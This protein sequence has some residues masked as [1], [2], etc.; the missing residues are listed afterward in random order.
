VKTELLGMLLSSVNPQLIVGEHMTSPAKTVSDTDSI[1][2]VEEVM[3]RYGLKAV[4]VVAEGT[5][6]CVGYLEQQTAAR[7]MSHKLGDIPVSEYMHRNVLTVEPEATLF[8]AMEIILNQRQRLVPVVKGGVVVGVLTRTDIMRLFVGDKSLRIPE[9][10]PLDSPARERNIRPLLSERLPGDHVE[11]LASAGKLGDALGYS[12]YAVGG[13]VRD[14]LLHRPNLDID[15]SVEGDGIAFAKA[16]AAKFSGRMHA[17]PKFKTAVVVFRNKAGEEQRIDVA[18]ARLEYYDHPGALPH[19]E[20]SSIKMDLFRRDFTINALAVQLNEARFGILVDPFGAQR[21]IKE[22]A[23]NVLHSLSF[24]EDPTRI[25]RGIRFEKRF[26]FH[27]GQQTERL[28]KNA[29]QLNMLERLSGSRLFHEMRHVL[30]EGVA[31]ACLQ[32]LESFNI[33]AAIH[34]QLKLHPNKLA[35]LKEAAPVLAWYTRLYTA[36]EPKPWQVYLQILC[37]GNKYPVVNEIL[38]A[39]GFSERAGS[40]FMRQ[41]ENLRQTNAKLPAWKEKDGSMSGLFQLLSRLSVESILVLMC[42]N[43]DR[44]DITRDLSHFLT[45]LHFEKPDITGEDIASFGARPSPVYGKVLQMVLAAKLDGQ[46]KSREEQLALAQRLV[47]QE[48][49]ESDPSFNSRETLRGRT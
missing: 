7:A 25:L 13:F 44:E 34:P 8:P 40:D 10:N 24:I 31:V 17:H 12:V 49:L 14:L 18:T 6:R 4:P 29:M 3:N 1:R 16:L 43:A 19:V 26:D 33:L 39:F 27:L 37:Q 30:D 36:R 38:A 48:G 5:A 9:G 22:R 11:L 47:R 28:I 21:D 41:R 2:D 35:L 45:R 23:V 20:L 42:L 32:R 15:I 46:V